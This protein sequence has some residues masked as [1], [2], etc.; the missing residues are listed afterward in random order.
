MK[1]A[2]LM[3]EYARLTDL[4]H[5]LSTMQV[6]K[7]ITDVEKTAYIRKFMEARPD[8]KKAVAQAMQVNR[9]EN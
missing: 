1:P 8:F 3:A 7:L 6:L 4:H 9:R 2:E 5:A